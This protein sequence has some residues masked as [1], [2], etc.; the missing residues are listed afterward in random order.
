MSQF[1]LPPAYDPTPVEE[2]WYTRWEEAGLFHAEPNPS[3]PPFC[4]TIPPPNITGELH[5]GHALCYEIQ[6]IL[7]RLQKMQGAAVLLLPGTDHASIATHNVV[8]RDMASEGLS[9]HDL[10]REKFLERTWNWKEHYG[11]TIEKQFRAL[12]FSFDWK[13]NRFT[14][15]PHY[16]DAVLEA[17]VRF[18]RDGLIYRGHRVINWCP[19]CHTAISDIE[20]E[21]RET[22][23]KLYHMAYPL[24]DGE[25]EVVVATTRPETMLGD[26]AVAVHPSDERYKPLVGKKVQ[27]PLT[28]RQIPV[29]TDEHANPEFGSGAVKIT[30]AHDFDD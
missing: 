21:D 14:M 8:E 2:K 4:I 30:P 25:G 15:D 26:T 13:R 3:S 20:I 24:I 9:R 19:R 16:A 27:L 10:G 5:I 11:G 23:A 29:I 18:Y 28:D 17:F 6:D 1:D 12:G 7:G 22:D